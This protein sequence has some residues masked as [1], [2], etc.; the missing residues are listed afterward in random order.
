[1]PLATAVAEAEARYVAANPA[2]HGIHVER[3]R[4]M[5]GGN[6]RTVIH[7]APFPL[8]HREGVGRDHHRR[9]RP[10]LRRLPRRVHGRPVR[11]LAP[12]HPRRRA[13]GAGRRHLLRR[14]ERVR[15]GARRGGLRAV[16]VDRPRPVHQ[17]RHRGEPDRASPL[18]RPRTG[19]RGIW[20]S[21][22]ATTAACSSSRTAAGSPINAPYPTFV[23]A[24]YN[25]ADGATRADRRARAPPGRRPRRAAAGL[26]AAASRP[27]RLPRRRCA[28]RDRE[29]G[30]C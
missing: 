30:A 2:S 12:D 8:T 29:H 14:A 15:G 1:M 11:A 17:L 4:S 5:P 7:V 25:D 22:A 23:V 27:S 28:R 6:T 18:A 16:P 20:C 21:R 26:A 10:R 3:Q 24:P 19:P 9:R 13:R